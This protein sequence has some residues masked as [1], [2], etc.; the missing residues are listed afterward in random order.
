[1]RFSACAH[2]VLFA[3]RAPVERR[4]LRQQRATAAANNPDAGLH[5][6]LSTRRHRTIVSHARTHERTHARTIARTTHA[7]THAHRKV[8]SARTVLAC[9]SYAPPTARP[10][11]HRRR[12]HNGRRRCFGITLLHPYSDSPFPAAGYHRNGAVR[13]SAHSGCSPP[14]S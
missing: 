5:A 1:M 2:R 7:L 10:P 6:A 11:V 4:R 12:V 3:M 14:L 13:S 9:Y 8:N